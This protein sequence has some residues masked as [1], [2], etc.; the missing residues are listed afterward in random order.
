M[1]VHLCMYS[2]SEPAEELQTNLY[3]SVIITNTGPLLLCIEVAVILETDISNLDTFERSLKSV[4]SGVFVWIDPSMC[5]NGYSQLQCLQTVQTERPWY[6]HVSNGN[7]CNII[8]KELMGFLL[9]RLWI[10]AK[11]VCSRTQTK[12]ITCCHTSSQWSGTPW[13]HTDQSCP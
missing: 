11:H 4:H 6:V 13:L 9:I 8:R 5:S 10:Q 7:V 2:L 3:P 1:L 12:P